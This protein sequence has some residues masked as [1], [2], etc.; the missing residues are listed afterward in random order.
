MARFVFSLE[1][2]LRQREFAEEQCQRQLAAARQKMQALQDELRALEQSMQASL[3]DVRNN[4]LTGRLDLGFL[5]AH[6]RYL[7]SVQRKGTT[8]AQKMALVQREVDAAQRALANA[9]K[10]RKILEKLREKQ[11]DRWQLDQARR[12]AAALDEVVTAMAGRGD[13]TEEASSFDADGVTSAA[14]TG[15]EGGHEETV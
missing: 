5:A 12:E 14:H 1:G 15:T 13:E 3:A 8:M 2:V 11:H 10:E 6:R 9:A 4:R 7:A